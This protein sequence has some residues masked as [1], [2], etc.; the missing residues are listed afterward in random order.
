[1][2]TIIDVA[3]AAGVAP[4]TVSYVISGKRAISPQ[5]RR[6]VEA[7]IRET[8]YRRRAAGAPAAAGRR[9]GVLGLVAP[10]GAACTPP[11]LKIVAGAAEA[12]RAHNLDL[13][14]VTHDQG[15]MGLRRVISAAL[16]DALVVLDVEQS[17]PR[18][19]V[20]LAWGRPAVVVGAPG[21]APGLTCVAPDFAAAG[22]ACLAHLAG[23][24]HRSIAHLGLV[25]AKTAGAAEK[26]AEGLHDNGKRLGVRTISTEC[27]ASAEAVTRRMT[28]LFTGDRPTALVV[29]EA[30]AALALSAAEWLRLRIPEDL[31]VI[32]AGLTSTGPP[33]ELT[34]IAVSPRELGTR[35]VELAVRQL[36]D[37]VAAGDDR[38]HPRLTIR[39]ST[40]PART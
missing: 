14:L 15:P 34:R 31:S 13:L 10:L 22:S 18:L 25:D 4:S 8:G 26:F 29:H 7:A 23:L 35:A 11:L 21:H 5:T 30:L 33:T 27:V 3:N 38:I 20:L 28:E 17:D 6:L 9:T 37:G 12:S 19:P 24:G 32:A 39:T 36:D 40:G 2:V 16:A 1:M